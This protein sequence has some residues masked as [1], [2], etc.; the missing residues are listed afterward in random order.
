MVVG[1]QGDE[2]DLDDGEEHEAVDDEGEHPD[3][4]IGVPNAVLKSAGVDVQRRRPNVAVQDPHALERQ[5]H[6]PP[7]A[8]LQYMHA[9]QR[10]TT[11][12]NL[13]CLKKNEKKITRPGSIICH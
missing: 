12:S 13:K 9:G 4:V 1:M 6:R 10:E 5:T 2:D 11:T 3:D 8:I 7:P